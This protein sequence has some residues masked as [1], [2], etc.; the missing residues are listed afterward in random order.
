MLHGCFVKIFHA[1]SLNF[2]CFIKNFAH[3]HRCSIENFY[4]FS[5]R[6]RHWVRLILGL[7]T[8][9]QTFYKKQKLFFFEDTISYAL[10]SKYFFNLEV[11]FLKLGTWNLAEN[12]FSRIIMNLY[13]LCS[14]LASFLFSWKKQLFFSKNTLFW[15]VFIKWYH[16]NWIVRQNWNN[17]KMKSLEGQNPAIVQLASKIA[18]KMYSASGWISSVF[19][20][21]DTGDQ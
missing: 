12:A 21:I 11:L 20:Y 13:T 9:R 3:T 5:A 16:F 4:V 10:F 1:C 14:K 8:F 19:K 15:N 17:F 2:P 7:L 6:V 18:K